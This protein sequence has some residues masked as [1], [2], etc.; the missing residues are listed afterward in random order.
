L[1][2]ERAAAAQIKGPPDCGNGS[3]FPDCRD[4]IA[5]HPASTPTPGYP[6]NAG[7]CGNDSISIDC[8]EA[9]N[10]GAPKEGG[11]APHAEGWENGCTE[12]DPCPK[13][14]FD[15]GSSP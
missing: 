11:D 6:P 14:D 10:A 3:T 4:P 1:T 9:M 7:P 2:P 12:G 15:R 8:G 5:A 13:G